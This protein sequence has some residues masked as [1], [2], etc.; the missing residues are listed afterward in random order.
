[1]GSF[2][3]YI[4]VLLETWW[5]VIGGALLLL[6]IL[7]R[8]VPESWERAQRVL[9]ISHPVFL[10]AAAIL[11]FVSQYLAYKKLNESTSTGLPPAI[12]QVL[13]V[14]EQQ[15]IPSNIG[16]AP[17]GLRVVVRP[18]QGD[19][20][21]SIRMYFNDEISSFDYDGPGPMM[22]G[23]SKF[24]AAETGTDGKVGHIVFMPATVGPQD[25]LAFKIFSKGAVRVLRVEAL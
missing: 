4:R 13:E 8:G 16:N 10:I 19:N 7:S 5:G 20:P 12:G 11:V 22:G 17:Y 6:D 15:R 14:I 23:V 9:K 24:A 25:S 3:H 21:L 2:L 1:M 18:P